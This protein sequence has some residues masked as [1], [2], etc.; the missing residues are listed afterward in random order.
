MLTVCVLKHS[1]LQQSMHISKPWITLVTLWSSVFSNC[2]RWG[3]QAHVGALGHLLQILISL[4]G[5]G[6]KQQK[7]ISAGLKKRS[8][9]VNT[10]LDDY[11]RQAECLGRPVLDFQQVIKY[12]FL[13]DF[14]LLHHTHNDITQK[15]WANP[16]VCNG[17]ISWMKIERAKEEIN[18]LN[19]EARCLMTFIWDSSVAQQQAIQHLHQ[20]NPALATE[21]QGRHRAQSSINTLLLQQLHKMQLLQGFSGQ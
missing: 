2:T 18:C 21:L 11:N 15:P 19:V 8:R 6:Y 9:A 20:T 1:R 14:K 7:K 17:M 3:Y 16:L 12:S 4:H 10:V 5:L 13:S